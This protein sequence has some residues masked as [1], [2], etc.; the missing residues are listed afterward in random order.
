HKFQL[1]TVLSLGIQII[2]LLEKL[3]STKYIHRDIKPNNFLI[4]IGNDNRNI[5]IMDFG[6][7]KQ[8]IDMNGKHISLKIDR[9]LIGT[10]RYA[11]INMH[12]GLEPSRRDDLE[13]VGYMLIYFL[14]GRLP[15]QG[16]KKKVD[17]NIKKSEKDHL[18]AIGEKK[19]C[20][21]LNELCGDIP[22]CFKK[23]IQYSRNLKFDEM[24]D[25]NY[26][27][28]LFISACKDN[29][30]DPIFE[31]AIDDKLKVSN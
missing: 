9:S 5:Y 29:N 3:H 21:T 24:P 23:L 16:I 30:I 17:M 7:S 31:W 2:T 18:E 11:S 6:L 28:S 26:L 15:W 19:L 25:Y 22:I 27:K 8:Y 14:K 1:C 13:S 12:N 4:G 10:A 20:T